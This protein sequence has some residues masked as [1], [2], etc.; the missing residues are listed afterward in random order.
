VSYRFY[1]PTALPKGEKVPGR[2]ALEPVW[3][4]RRIKQ[5][6]ALLAR[7]AWIFQPIA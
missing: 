6:P 3:T 1:T 2:W 4:T 5:S 7:D